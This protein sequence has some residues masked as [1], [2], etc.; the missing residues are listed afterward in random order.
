MGP[1]SCQQPHA[2]GANAPTEIGTQHSIPMP[3]PTL[4]FEQATP[5]PSRFSQVESGVKL[6]ATSQTVHSP[7]A[8]D[9]SPTSKESES[10]EGCDAGRD[11]KHVSGLP[12]QTA[13]PGEQAY[14]F[15]GKEY[16][17]PLAYDVQMMKA[18]KGV[19]LFGVFEEWDLGYPMGLS[20]ERLTPLKVVNEAAEKIKHYM[21]FGSN[22]DKD[23]KTHY[24]TYSRHK[25]LIAAFKDTAANIAKRETHLSEEQCI[26]LGVE[27]WERVRVKLQWTVCQLRE[28]LAG[29][30]SGRSR[31]KD[32]MSQVEAQ[33][34]DGKSAKTAKDN[35]HYQKKSRLQNSLP[36]LDAL[37]AEARSD[38]Y[39]IV[40]LWARFHR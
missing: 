5:F 7:V 13:V 23:R 24:K 3:S 40:N 21:P 36:P 17:L 18:D 38:S 20:G 26:L 10:K 19:T 14:I 34:G 35:S 32:G 28:S 25:R 11:G 15:E 6:T 31:G 1:T 30:F 22:K 29:D 39:V 8:Y 37:L 4:E 16:S 33:G 12:S 9:A 2:S 27:Y